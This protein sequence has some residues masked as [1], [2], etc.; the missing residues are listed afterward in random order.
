AVSVRRVPEPELMD[1][2]AQARAYAEAD[3]SEAHDRFVAHIGARFGPLEGQVLDLGC[4]PADPTVRLA[5]ANPAVSIV[6]VDAGPVMLGLAGE[7][8]ER[9]GLGGRI[10]LEQRRLP[11]PSLEERRFDAVVSNSLLHHLPDPIVLWTTAG[12][13]VRPGGVVAVMDLLRPADLAGVDRLVAQI[14]EAPAVLRAD[15]RNSLLAAYR[16][17]EVEAQLAAAGLVDLSVEQISD[18]HLFAGGRVS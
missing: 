14:G 11:D 6:G 12:R 16:L 4:G 1:E 15:F 13:C 2:P 10:R 3:F 5:R 9:A 17:E 18:R 7:R 8:I